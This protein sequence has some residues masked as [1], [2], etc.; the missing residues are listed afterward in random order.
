MLLRRP[1]E[2]HTDEDLTM[3]NVKPMTAPILDKPSDQPM[4]PKV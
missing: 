4:S 2:I 3:T 1:N